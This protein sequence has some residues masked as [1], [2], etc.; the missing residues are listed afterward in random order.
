MGDMSTIC[1]DPAPSQSVSVGHWQH[2][3]DEGLCVP[4]APSTVYQGAT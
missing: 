4:S 3:V 1:K 2:Q